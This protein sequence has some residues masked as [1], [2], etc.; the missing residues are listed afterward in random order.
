M[1]SSLPQ[2]T[3]NSQLF[4]Q[5][6]ENI[7]LGLV[8]LDTE[9]EEII[10]CNQHASA[11]INQIKVACHYNG[12]YTLLQPAIER[13]LAAPE[14]HEEKL[15]ENHGEW[16]IDYSLTSPGDSRY[17]SILLQD[18]TD[19]KRLDSIAEAAV[20][21]N[22]VGYIFSG[23]RHELGNPLNSIKMALTV[24]QKNMDR[25]SP[26]EI[27]VYFSRV[28]EDISR[29]E[30]LL[31]SFKN[32]NMYER[33]QTDVMD[34]SDFIR[35]NTQL[36]AAYSGVK[37]KEVDISVDVQ[38]GSEWVKVDRRALQQVMMN[39]LSNA[40]DAMHHKRNAQLE[41]EASTSGDTTLLKIRDN[42]CG[43][44]PE[45]LQDIFNPFFT[46]KEKGTGLGLA[47]SQKMLS[48]INCSIGV[49]SIPDS[50]TTFTIS[51]PKA[52]SYE[53]E[54]FKVKHGSTEQPAHSS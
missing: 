52:R 34:L 48:Q 28:F 4:P 17:V 14:G 50:G 2:F 54:A 24:L 5:I 39:L 47:L 3:D 7:H 46:T 22:N 8:L 6:L 44:P 19:Q 45:T 10:F 33:P 49:S 30:Q 42:G 29:I 38:P 40:M 13:L 11:I 12:L 15:V 27:K 20:N 1:P 31:K 36:I 9:R 23:I 37:D 25:Y 35:H 51:I 18:I 41:I 26:K 53:I 32:F 21:M 16:F 43:I